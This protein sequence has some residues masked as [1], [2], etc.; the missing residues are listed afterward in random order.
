MPGSQDAH[1]L[2][3]GH[4]PPLPGGYATGTYPSPGPMVLHVNVQ[5]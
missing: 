2:L 1:D 3:R 4:S 5:R